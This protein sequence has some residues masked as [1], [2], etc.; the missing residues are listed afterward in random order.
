MALIGGRAGLRGLGWTAWRRRHEGWTR[1]DAVPVALP[2][3]G[4]G[5]LGAVSRS[6]GLRSGHSGAVFEPVSSLRKLQGRSALRS[7][8]PGQHPLVGGV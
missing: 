3:P 2:R 6:P 4:Q 5:S 1:E 7:R 8:P